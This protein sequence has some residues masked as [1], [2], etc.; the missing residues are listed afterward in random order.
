[1]T[2]RTKCGK[3]P[4]WKDLPV[5]VKGINMLQ[6]LLLPHAIFVGIALI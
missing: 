3:T 5:V 6:V 2:I 4:Q 1:M